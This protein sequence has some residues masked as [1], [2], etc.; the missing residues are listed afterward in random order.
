MSAAIFIAIAVLSNAQTVTPNIGLT[1]PT[2]GQLNWSVPLNS[3]FSL[4]DLYLSGNAGIPGIRFS[5]TGAQPTCNSTFRGNLFIVQ[6]NGTSTSDSVQVCTLQANGTYVWTSL[7]GS[8]P[9][10]TF[11]S[12]TSGTNTTA[13]ML[14]GSGASL[15]AVGTGTII[16]TAVPA[17]GI[18]GILPVT[19]GGTGTAT[20]SL[21]AG[22]NVSITG[23]WPNQTISTSNV[24]A[25]A[26]LTSGTNSTATMVVGSGASLSTTG[27][28]IIQATTMGA[29]GLTGLV[30]ISNGGTG[31]SSPSLVGGSNISISGSWPNQTIT[32]T[33]G[34]FGGLTSGTNTAA[35]MLVGT[36]ASLAATGSGTIAATSAPAAGVTGILPV[37]AGG[38]GTSSPSL[39]AGTNTTIT[40]S[41]PNQTI[42]STN[43]FN[44]LTSGTNN[45]ATM[46]IGT[47]S[48]MSASGSGTIS[49][50]TVPAS[51]ITGTLAVANGGT[52]TTTST[53]SGNLVLSTSPTLVSPALGTPTAEVLTN[54]TGLPLTTGVTGLLPIS[55]GGTG[56]ASPGLVAGSNVTISGSWPNQTISS[57]GGGGSAFSALTSG[58]NT[59]AAMV[60]GT[61]ASL[62]TAGSGSINANLVN[63]SG[64]PASATVL[65]SNASSQLASASTTGSGNVV[66]STSPTLVTPALGTPSSVTL[67]NGTG[68]PL[69]TGVTGTLQAAQEPAHTG[70][71]TNSAGSL[72]TSVVKVNGGA[73]PASAI[74]LGSNTSNQLIAATTTGTGST[75]VLG[76]SPTLV[77]PALG[78]PSSA[79]LT[80]ATGLPLTTGVSGLLPIA[81]GGTGTATPS[82]VA[83]SNISISGSWPN[84]TINGTGSTAFSSLT[85]GSNTTATMVVGSGASL[86]PTGTGSI[87]A[88]QINAAAV[89]ASATVLGSNA[90]NQL[91]AASTTGSGNV[92]LATSPVLVTPSLGTPSALTL[93]NATG[94]P[95]STGVSGI[96]PIANG[97]NG[98]N[99]PGLVAG[100][101][102]TLSGTWPTQTINAASISTAFSALTSGTNATAAMIVGTGA[103]LA[104]SGSGTI[105]ATAMPA[106]GLTGTVSVAHGGT[107]TTTPS[108]VAG[109]NITISGSWPNQTITASSTGA[110]AF[111]A[112]TS[113]TNTT[114]AMVV[115]TGASL[116]TSGTGSISA[117]Q[118]NGA[119]VPTSAAVLSS[120]GANQL[121][122]ASTTGSGNVVLSTNPTL[123]GPALGTPTSGVLTN[124]TGLPLTSGVTGILP[125]TNGGTGTAS[126]SLVAGT[127]IS[128]TGS[129]PNQT[130]NAS[131][132]AVAFNSITSGTNTT[133]AMLLGTGSSLAT[134][135]SGTIAATSV[136]VAG[137]TGLTFSGSTTKAVSTTGSLTTGDCAA[138]D[139]SGN[140]IDSGSGCG[141]PSILAT[142]PAIGWVCDGTTINS[143][144]VI[145]A[146]NTWFKNN[147]NGTMYFPPNSTCLKVSQTSTSSIVVDTMLLGVVSANLVGSNTA[148]VTTTTAG[149]DNINFQTGQSE[150]NCFSGSVTNP[151]INYDY[152]AAPIATVSAGSTTVT[153]TG[154]TGSV[155]DR[156]LIYGFDQQGSGFPPNYRY[157]ERHTV[158]AISGTT[159]TLDSPL[160]Y[161][162]NS[163]WPYSNSDNTTAPAIRDLSQT[164]TGGGT[165]QQPRRIYVQGFD[166]SK[167][168]VSQ[169]GQIPVTYAG[170]ADYVE[171]NNV[172]FAYLS[173]EGGTTL[174]VRNSTMQW[175]EIDKLQSKVIIENSTF[176]GNLLSPTNACVVSGSG[177]LYAEF[178][179]VTFKCLPAFASRN[180]V[181]NNPVIYSQSSQPYGFLSN[182]QLGF[183]NSIQVNNPKL[184]ENG[185]SQSGVFGVGN[186]YQITIAAVPTSSTFTVTGGNV[187]AAQEYIGP[188][189]KLYDHV[190]GVFIGTATAD[191]YLNSSVFTVPGTFLGG[192]CSTATLGVGGSGYTTGDIIMVN[193]GTASGCEF[194]V[195]ATAG[196]VTAIARAAAG[197]GYSTGTGLSTTRLSGSGSGATVNIT[198]IMA[199]PYAGQTVDINTNAQNVTVVNPVAMDFDINTIPPAFDAGLTAYVNN[200]SMQFL[201]NTTVA[202]LGTCNAAST[203]ATK[204]VTDAESQ[205]VLGGGGYSTPTQ[206]YCI[207]SNQFGGNWVTVSAVTT[208]FLNGI[209]T[210]TSATTLNGGTFNF[211]LTDT[212]P[213][214][215][216][217]NGSVTPPSLG[218][219][220]AKGQST[221]G[222]TGQQ[223]GGG[224]TVTCIGGAGG[225]A[226]SGSLNGYGGGCDLE[227]GAAGSGAGSGGG[228]GPVH[229]Q[230]TT[231]G[232][233]DIGYSGGAVCLGPV[234]G[235][236]CGNGLFGIYMQGSIDIVSGTLSSQAIVNNSA[237][238]SA[239]Y[240]TIAPV[241]GT[242]TP[243]TVYNKVT[244]TASFSIM[245]PP[246][247]C[248]SSTQNC[249]IVLRADPVTGPFTIMTGGNFYAAYSPVVGQ[250]AIF[251]YD[252]SALKWYCTG[253]TGGG[254]APG[255]STNAIQYNNAGALG[256]LTV[257]SADSLIMTNA[258]GV[259]GIGTAG[260]SGALCLGVGCPGGTAYTIDIVTSVV[261]RLAA[262]ETVTGVWTLQQLRLAATTYAALPVSCT[263]G[264]DGQL[265]YIT[266]STTQTWGAAVTTGG[267][268][269][270]A[271]ILCDGSVPQWTVF[272]K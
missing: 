38:S 70:D 35:A 171:F 9:S 141:G 239:S 105:T 53:G 207:G 73:V 2:V 218:F 264:A 20:P 24:P 57:S 242:L 221:T 210:A 159:I 223:A 91:S 231:V 79:V 225:D 17:T 241:T 126:P 222:T 99:A 92:V 33:S 55:S 236:T 199:N 229:I 114:A 154:F 160:S 146:T 251:A 133:A 258:S 37:S 58:T 63:G 271:A 83:G 107:G 200:F 19:A 195:T 127:N 240:A 149:S 14:V 85:S 62:T 170:G 13:A 256:G 204:W 234:S 120:N 190:S 7:G 118:V 86:S 74:V 203:F 88:N 82:L 180:T 132:G 245:T 265:A 253:C 177:N 119:A 247:G 215:T 155:G 235:G 214:S 163:A 41:W 150:F 98:T 192:A 18:T 31:T 124:L 111:S 106:S 113:S 95:L 110:T 156:V 233:T 197:V 243:T 45:A 179:D 115:G 68:L 71:M 23:S 174:V 238:E 255:G 90:S 54:A 157:F 81:N 80:N 65:A 50:T 87:N 42:N 22:S 172:K 93:T 125:L 61:G 208:P 164:C 76:T 217:G 100:T 136:P 75:V 191:P 6:G 252:S 224:Q 139:G 147:P 196:A 184:Y 261:P 10:V 257:P 96:L 4:L 152:T 123:I 205:S 67:T 182:G 211:T 268:G 269:L 181:Y 168:T 246:A 25:F 34:S 84:Q 186:G 64:I 30:S 153:A 267:G 97:G 5:T 138:W 104:A 135:G 272:A 47:G 1:L 26:A 165:V 142:S 248:G 175:M 161:S 158:T 60:V 144:T 36:G 117:N 56:T 59:A 219:I 173:P 11:S 270:R 188:L 187:L 249:R 122:T 166:F 145:A 260:T 259:P 244:G 12:L 232:T 21:V 16:A 198:A 169:A 250:D 103:S 185:V 206:V 178:D 213:A 89:P 43:G 226:P 237:V 116:S 129:W 29:S 121:T 3:D 131:G 220:G 51:G 48:S 44:S 28:G 109:T 78:T 230:R 137:V 209:Q 254:S 128:I 27:A 201:G 112:L 49:A 194:T 40:G 66:L 148:L 143:N 8:S 151:T 193:Q 212:Q 263:S 108:L 69:A 46:V 216:T 228:V 32:S 130:I 15:G 140:A 167:T 52:G 162:Y 227:G 94:L 262:A 189:T 183:Q 102:I 202:D 134:T 176:T 72:V 77:T 101:N 39:V 266:D